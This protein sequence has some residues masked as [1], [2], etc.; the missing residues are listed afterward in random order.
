MH[1]YLKWNHFFQTKLNFKTNNL[2][3][4][5]QFQ[6]SLCTSF[7]PQKMIE[8]S[9]YFRH[10]KRWLL[11]DER[12]EWNWYV[13]FKQHRIYMNSSSKFQ[14]PFELNVSLVLYCQCPTTWDCDHDWNLGPFVPTQIHVIEK[15][16]NNRNR[17]Y[18]SWAIGRE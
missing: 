3:F 14:V 17:D 8:S 2:Y 11:V 15:K 4:I 9:F 10:L 6:H 5:F 16:R 1:N 7:Y 13:N 18:N 12:N